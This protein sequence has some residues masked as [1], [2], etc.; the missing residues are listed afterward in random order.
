MDSMDS[1]KTSLVPLAREEKILTTEKITETRPSGGEDREAN[2]G[3]RKKRLSG[4]FPSPSRAEES[5]DDS[6]EA[7]GSIIN[8]VV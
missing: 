4:K 8:I 3:Q 5:Q 1:G 7:S 6:R 2:Q